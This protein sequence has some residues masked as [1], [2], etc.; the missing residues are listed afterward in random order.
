MISFHIKS[1]THS[2]L[3]TASKFLLMAGFVIATIVTVVGGFQDYFDAK[4]LL[5]DYRTVEAA[6]N[7]DG[8]TEERKKKGRIVKTFHF[9]YQF[10]LDGQSYSREFT[11]SESNSE[12]YLNKETMTIAVDNKDHSHFDRLDVVQRHANIGEEAKNVAIAIALIAFFAWI[13]HMLITRKLFLPREEA[14][15]A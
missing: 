2:K 4:A 15:A 13:M 9:N 1:S 14:T 10:E 6:V 7:F 3:T 11:T 12:D 8:I 5:S